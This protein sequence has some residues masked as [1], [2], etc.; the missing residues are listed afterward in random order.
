MDFVWRFGWA[1][2]SRDAIALIAGYVG[3]RRVLE[4]GA[5]RGLWARLL[6]GAGV[7]IIATDVMPGALSPTENLTIRD[8]PPPDLTYSPVELLDAVAAVERYADREVLLMCWPA[9]SEPYA[10]EAL[11]A[12]HGDIVVYVGEAK[13]GCTGGDALHDALASGWREASE[14]AIPQWDG[15]YD[16]IVIYERR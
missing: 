5:G 3:Q 13:G 8:N 10:A 2:P 9:L 12:F 6:A 4:I 1:V 15:I 11:R 14:I 7:D 16:W